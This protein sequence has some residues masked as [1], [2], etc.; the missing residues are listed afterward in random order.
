MR[1]QPSAVLVGLLALVLAV[2]SGTA[3]SSN[4]GF[5]DVQRD[6]KDF[7]D[8]TVTVG[9]KSLTVTWQGIEIGPGISTWLREKV[10]G[11]GG[12]DER[13][14]NVSE[15]EAEVAKEYVKMFLQREFNIY[16]G[17]S[18]YSGYLLIDYA[19]PKGAEVTQL[20]VTGL[21]GPVESDE[22]IGL[23]FQAAIGFATR[24]AEVHTIKLDMGRYYF[25]EVNES[26]AAEVVGDSTLT[27]RAASNWAIVADDI[28]PECA[29][30]AYDAESR[31]MV[32]TAEDINCFTG[33]SGV[34][35]AFSIS[36]RD[37]EGASTIPG[38]ELALLP[39]ALFGAAW[40]LRRR[41]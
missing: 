34:L 4:P 28:Q 21:V 1:I 10:D 24:S 37:D 19:N 8:V 30:D 17:D 15:D 16:S 40:A 38:F 2:P 39:I 35:L 31:A 32:F 20:D 12:D 6:L 7:G 13:D 27:I 23:G 9:P 3:Q 26:K 11:L 29:H 25:R 36:G 33:H 18:R 14:G 22:G 41:L 5:E